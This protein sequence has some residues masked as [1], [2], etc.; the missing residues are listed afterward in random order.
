MAKRVLPNLKLLVA[1][2]LFTATLLVMVGIALSPKIGQWQTAQ[3]LKTG[4]I[5][6]D[7]QRRGEALAIVA[8]N[9]QE[10]DWVCDIAI[11][12]LTLATPNQFMSIVYALDQAGQWDVSIVGKERWLTYLMLLA[13]DESNAARLVAASAFGLQPE[14]I[15]DA[16][17]VQS[18]TDLMSDED[19]QVRFNAMTSAAL[20]LSKAHE[21][22]G[23]TIQSEHV[24]SLSQAMMQ[25]TGD[26][27]PM[28]AR[29]AWIVL[30][31][32]AR[33]EVMSTDSFAKINSNASEDPM[34]RVAEDWSKTRETPQIQTWN[35]PAWY[36]EMSE[37]EQVLSIQLMMAHP[38][39]AVRDV[40]VVLAANQWGQDVS[41]RVA[42][43]LIVSVDPHARLSGAMLAGLTQSNP[44]GIG[45]G[46]SIMLAKH[47]E[48]SMDDLLAMSE[49]E[50][51][52][53][54]L[55]KEDALQYR[56]QHAEDWPSLQVYR[57][58]L[59]LRGEAA[60]EQVP[61]ADMPSY[62][63][64]LL[65]RDDVP[66]TTTLLAMM[67][68]G[69]REA[70]LLWL[71]N[72]T[73]QPPMELDPLLAHQGWHLVLERYWPE[74]PRIDPEADDLTRQLQYDI[75]RNWTLMFVERP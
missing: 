68:A 9:A 45:G 34:V 35:A 16:H 44:I 38:D 13:S 6:E 33:T 22:L 75:L 70:A 59:W 3:R 54:G 73:G 17:A 37:L 23:K 10:L 4:L 20:W 11:E 5:H 56:A 47:P 31:L 43:E 69:D 58:A 14:G 32:L 30:G 63:E 49:Q 42:R 51:E 50:L 41:K 72:P 64:K 66:R 39:A 40:A 36:A 25:R 1:S 15:R 52:P 74:A 57:L 48:L 29:H 62:A 12:R 19:S 61:L 46:A 2:L 7:D 60:D 71:I 24:Q 53:L 27:E 8:R 21:L 28:I 55:W 26:E 65:L 18:L 67:A